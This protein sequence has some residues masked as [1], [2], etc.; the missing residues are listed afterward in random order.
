MKY[1]WEYMIILNQFNFLM[2][3]YFKKIFKETLLKDVDLNSF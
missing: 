2:K 3:N 1:F